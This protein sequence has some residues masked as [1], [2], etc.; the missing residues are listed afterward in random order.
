MD[1]FEQVDPFFG[2]DGD[3]EAPTGG[4]KKGAG[5]KRKLS[6]AEQNK[7]RDDKKCFAAGCKEKKYGNS[8]FCKNM[9]AQWTQMWYQAENDEKKDLL[10]KQTDDPHLA[11]LLFDEFQRLT[12]AGKYNKRLIEW[13]HWRQIFGQRSEKRNRAAEE[14]MDFGD[15][16][17]LPKNALLVR[18]EQWQEL[19]DKWNVLQS[20]YDGELEDG[21]Q[22]LWI[23]QNQ[24]RFKDQIRYADGAFEEGS[25]SLKNLKDSDKQDL[26]DFAIRSAPA[27]CDAFFK[28]DAASSGE[29]PPAFEKI[30]EK[31]DEPKSK[32]RRVDV[33]T[34]SS[35]LLG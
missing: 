29:S 6:S 4:A 24:V 2:R 26:K 27:F 15:W 34:A 19:K 3:D 8:K 30:E 31:F 12:P 7:R 35:K 28:S 32:R 20:K 17:A 5:A 21:V 25:K 9:A 1:D 13:G 22:K 23:P 33:D 14:L 11:A 18:L 16:T 10:K